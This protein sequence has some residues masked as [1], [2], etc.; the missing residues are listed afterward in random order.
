MDTETKSPAFTSSSPES[1]R[2][3]SSAMT[4]SDFSPAF[5]T[6]KFWSTRTTSAVMT[7]PTR[8]SFRVRLSSNRASNDSGEAWGEAGFDTALET[9]AMSFG[10]DLH[11]RGLATCAAGWV[12]NGSATRRSRYFT[13][14]SFS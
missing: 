11:F 12:K 6:T 5:T 3:S 7:S 9:A 8:I 4:L 13:F 14:T 10:K 2:N 1:V